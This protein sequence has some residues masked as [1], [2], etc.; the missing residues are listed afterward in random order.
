MK[1]A[2]ALLLAVLFGLGVA[3]PALAADAALPHNGRVVIA[4]EG[5]VTIPAG[6][7]ADLVVVFEGDAIIRGEVNTV[8]VF[9]GNAILEGATVEALVVTSGS[10]T[11][12]AASLVTG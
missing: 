4:S 5:D 12:D 8:A 3:A 9:T 7:H 10:A 6:E 11:I 2:L 1:R